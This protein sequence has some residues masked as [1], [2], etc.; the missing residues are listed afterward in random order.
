[1]LFDVRDS[2]PVLGWV[3]LEA[4]GGYDPSLALVTSS[5]VWACFKPAFSAVSLALFVR[6]L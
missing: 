3:K 5:S 2:V 1:M 4:L 6:P